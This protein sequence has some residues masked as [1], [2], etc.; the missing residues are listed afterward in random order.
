MHYFNF[1]QDKRLHAVFGDQLDPKKIL[2]DLSI[3]SG[4]KINPQSD[5]VF[6]DEIQDCPRA[7]TSLKYFHEDM[8]ELAVVSAGSLLGVVLSEESFPVGKV[9]YLRLCPMNFEEFLMAIEDEIGL[10]CF[11]NMIGSVDCSVTAHDHLWLRLK[12]YFITGGMPE[13]VA[14]YLNLRESDVLTRF[15]TLRALQQSLLDSYY[16]DFAKHA[17]RVNSMH[18]ISVFENV[19]L[20]LAK[21]IDGSVQRYL[22]R[23]VIPNKRGYASLMGPISWLEQAGL[24]LKTKICNRADIPIESFCK[25]NMFKL[26]IF[27]IGLLGCMLKLPLEALVAQDYGITKGF[28][29]ENF[30]AQELRAS[31]QPLYSWAESTSEIEFLLMKNGS[32]VPTEVKSGLRTHARSLSAYI[33]RYNPKIAITCTARPLQICQDKTVRNFPLYLAGHMV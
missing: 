8:P 24:I 28:F 15:E 10:E 30:V 1:E 19:P 20:Q 21:N 25:Q 33:K 3:L 32:I 23:D 7:L 2:N 27:D 13:I 9:E 22:F 4:Q 6:F 18:I 16:K 26:Y 5:C 11:R 14:A 17:G 29:A 12:E 31:G